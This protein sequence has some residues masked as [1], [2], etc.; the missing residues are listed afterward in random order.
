[1]T[2]LI[3]V[4]LLSPTNCKWLLARTIMYTIRIIGNLKFLFTKTNNSNNDES[5]RLLII[6]MGKHKKPNGKER[7]WKEMGKQF[8]S[9]SFF[10]PSFYA[11]LL[12][13]VYT[14]ASL[15]RY[16]E[17]HS[18]TK[19]FYPNISLFLLSIRLAPFLM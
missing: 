7:Y 5:H 16:S 19:K 14:N 4:Y 9:E 15:V 10:V 3:K 2:I 13:H 18:K 8:S 1:M 11:C 17:S 6:P 12:L